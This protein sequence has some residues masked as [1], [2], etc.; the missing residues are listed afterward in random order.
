VQ[1]PGVFAVKGPD[2]WEIAYL[3]APEMGRVKK[4]NIYANTNSFLKRALGISGHPNF[5]GNDGTITRIGWK[6][7]NKSLVM[8]S[9]EAYNLEMGVANEL[10]PEER[11]GPPASCMTRPTPEDTTNF[12]AS[13]AAISSDLI[14][15][16]NF[17][18]FLAPPAES[19]RGIPGNPSAQSIANG[20]ALFSQIHCD[21]CH[22]SALQ[23]SASNFAASHSGPC[24][25]GFRSQCSDLPLSS[26]KRAA[27]AGPV[28]LS[29]IA[30]GTIALGNLLGTSRDQSFGFDAKWPGS[31]GASCRGMV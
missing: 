10:F 6:A 13:G 15:F 25:P 18:R 29:A 26:T 16:A 11:S 20:R 12:P 14:A 27:E 28:E 21:G 8:F 5:S 9:G 31:E 19:G 17:M 23:T 24:E 1:A 22:T 2:R 30:V 4:S 3:L 7:Q